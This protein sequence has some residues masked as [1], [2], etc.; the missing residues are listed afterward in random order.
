M[1]R[2]IQVQDDYLNKIETGSATVFCTP[3]IWLRLCKR[4]SCEKNKSYSM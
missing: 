3:V 4:G 1:I 2:N